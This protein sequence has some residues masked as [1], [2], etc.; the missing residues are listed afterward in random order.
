MNNKKIKKKTFYIKMTSV[1]DLP[2]EMVAR[3]CREMDIPELENFL[4][5]S[6]RN[7]NLC[8]DILYDKIEEEK[9]QRKLMLK[10]KILEFLSKKPGIAVDVSAM[11]KTGER[12]RGYAMRHIATEHLLQIPGYNIF[13]IP[14]RYHEILDI[15][16]TV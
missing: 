8:Y 14:E 5:V 11:S 12:I 2:D 15:M 9:Y 10:N 7:Y 3:L 1:D 4:E 16:N 13:V 6:A